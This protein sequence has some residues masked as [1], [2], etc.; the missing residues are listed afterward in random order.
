[1]PTPTV[2]AYRRE[3]QKARDRAL[4]LVLRDGH[5]LFLAASS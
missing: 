5:T 4:V 2:D 1:V 3:A